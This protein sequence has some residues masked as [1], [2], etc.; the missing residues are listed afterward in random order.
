MPFSSLPE[1]RHHLCVKLMQRPILLLLAFL[2]TVGAFYG[3]IGTNPPDSLK[4]QPE[5]NT[6]L[7]VRG[8][9][10]GLFG[11]SF[12]PTRRNHARVSSARGN[13]STTTSQSMFSEKSGK[14]GQTKI[15]REGA[16]LLRRIQVVL[17]MISD[18]SLFHLLRLHP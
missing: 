16:F 7:P 3:S 15:R 14:F 18:S 10:G 2:S 4:V 1:F 13:D 9:S 11:S 6:L 5:E 12:A 17:C 8:L